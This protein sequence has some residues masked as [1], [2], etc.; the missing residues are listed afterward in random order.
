VNFG[1]AGK[2]S[3]APNST[4]V[5]TNDLG[6]DLS[7]GSV[8]VIN[9]PESVNIKNSAGEIVKVNAGE[10]A[11]AAASASKRAPRRYAGLTWWEITA[12][13]TAVTVTAVVVAVVV[14]GDDT[15]TSPVR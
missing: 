3:L 10:T 1:K 4:Y 8:T 6:G 5:L 9:A 12:I 11:D 7:A 13:V 14:S 15:P 2:I